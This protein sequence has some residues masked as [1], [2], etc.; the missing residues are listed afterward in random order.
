MYQIKIEYQGELRTHAVHLQSG[1]SIITDAPTDNKGKGKAFS[2]TDLAVSALGSCILT[3]MG[4]AADQLGL[5]IRGTRTEITK[6]MSEKPRKI[7]KIIMHIYFPST[8]S[9]KH[10]AILEKSAYS[11][12]VCQSFHPDVEKEIIFHYPDTKDDNEL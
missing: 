10:Q 8:F 7:T 4:I 12:P 6:I 9:S 11:C 5:N 1:Q 3:I 2:P